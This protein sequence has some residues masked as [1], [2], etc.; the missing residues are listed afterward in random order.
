MKDRST[1]AD[2]K[3]QRRSAAGATRSSFSTDT[4]IR[5]KQYKVTGKRTVKF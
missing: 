3:K 4:E 1:P 5:K 2:G